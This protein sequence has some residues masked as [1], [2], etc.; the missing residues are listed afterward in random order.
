MER[1]GIYEA[2]ARL[3]DLVER[4]SRGDEV[5]I[6]RHGKAVARLVPAGARAGSGRTSAFDELDAFAATVKVRR[7]NLR[8]AIEAGRR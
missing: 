2:K 7:F 6:T 1:V 5:T 3:S 8:K 4:A